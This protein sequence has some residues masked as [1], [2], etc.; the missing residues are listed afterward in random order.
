MIINQIIYQVQKHN[1]YKENNNN[2]N[3]L[4]KTDHT[5]DQTTL[6][7]S[8]KPHQIVQHVKIP[9]NSLYKTHKTAY[10]KQ[11]KTHVQ[12]TKQTNQPATTTITNQKTHKIF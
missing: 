5:H 4:S 1:H 12:I 8:Q 6:E 9:Q 3:N 10:L 7:P 11:T 2:N